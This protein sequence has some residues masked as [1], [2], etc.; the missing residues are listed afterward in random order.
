MVWILR[1]SIVLFVV[2][3]GC[4]ECSMH[5]DD[6]FLQIYLLYFLWNLKRSNEQQAA[7]DEAGEEKV[8]TKKDL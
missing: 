7:E 2:G 5:C 8:E 6:L 3:I 4:H 1:A